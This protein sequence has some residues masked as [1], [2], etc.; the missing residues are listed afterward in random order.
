MRKTLKKKKKRLFFFYVFS[1]FGGKATQLSYVFFSGMGAIE[2]VV[3][4][5]TVQYFRLIFQEFPLFRIVKKS[6]FWPLFVKH[7]EER[8][9]KPHA[10]LKKGSKYVVNSLL[11]SILFNSQ[12]E[13]VFCF[14]FLL[15]TKS[16][17]SAAN[18]HCQHRSRILL[19]FHL[20]FLFPSV[21]ID[22]HTC[23][24]DPVYFFFGGN[25]KK[26]PVFL[27]SFCIFVS[28]LQQLPHVLKLEGKK[29]QQILDWKLRWMFFFPLFLCSLYS[30]HFLE[31]KNL[32]CCFPLFFAIHSGINKYQLRSNCWEIATVAA[33]RINF[34]GLF[35]EENARRIKSFKTYWEK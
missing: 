9:R 21:H 4:V 5:D 31:K 34:F 30:L 3:V 22:T 17:S 29:G 2:V 28:L 23:N 35:S 24:K 16:D 25:G 18:R 1:L 14:F 13:T 27:V 26:D 8:Q 32:V 10:E 19:V 6:P 11:I 7:F 12:K 20:H 33:R 15:F